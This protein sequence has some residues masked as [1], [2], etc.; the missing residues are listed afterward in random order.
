MRQTDVAPGKGI[1]PDA[2]TMRSS[3]CRYYLQP[4]LCFAD[5]K[6]ACTMSESRSV[7]ASFDG[8]CQ[9]F[10]PDGHMGLG[11][12]IDDKDY[13][14][15]VPAK[16]GNSNN[17]A[18]YM[19]LIRLFETVAAFPVS[20]ELRISGDSQ[21]V[22]YQLLG[23]WSVNA[24]HLIPLHTKATR[25]IE[26]LTATGWKVDLRW[27]DRTKNIRA[28][29][30]STTA[31][32]EHGV[33]FAQHHPAP[34]YTPVFR[35][36]AEVLGISSIRF[37][38]ALDALGLRDGGKMPATRA[39][40]DG[41]AQKRFD[42]FGIVVDWNKEKVSAAVTAFFAD[43]DDTAAIGISPTG[44][45]RE[46]VVAQHLCGHE[47]AVGRRPSKK[48]LEEVAQSLCRDCLAGNKFRFA[49]ERAAVLDLCEAGDELVD[50]VETIV[51]DRRL[52]PGVFLASWGKWAHDRREK[53][54][55]SFRETCEK[56][57]S[58][59][60]FRAFC[61]SLDRLKATQLNR[62]IRAAQHT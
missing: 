49:A 37:G 57:G 18:E 59:P 39:L 28:D 25:L 7:A 22:I 5:F 12:V 13:H 38:R 4:D 43:K 48:T 33:E 34:G 15:Y 26:K 16:I 62:L 6:A 3:F 21:L 30:A 44:P 24:Q 41:Y 51:A 10:N 23:E 46:P 40:D 14:E 32:A 56:P 1:F 55:D 45:K 9:P 54:L 50:A 2:R 20:G 61:D 17:V 47:I 60:D 58:H 53:Q 35:E 42:G 31:L 27:V 8:A 36:M 52:R 11:W 29:E 19:A